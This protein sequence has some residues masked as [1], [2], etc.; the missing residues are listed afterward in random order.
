MESGQVD[1]DDQGSRSGDSQG[2]LAI[3]PEAITKPNTHIPACE[4]NMISAEDKR[5]IV[6]CIHCACVLDKTSLSYATPTNTTREILGR[7]TALVYSFQ[8]FSLL[9]K[10]IFFYDVYPSVRICF[11]YIFTIFAK[12]FLL[13]ILLTKVDMD[14]IW[15][16]LR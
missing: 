2:Q 3:A 15:L 8:Y 9:A 7:S 6:F 14:W 11:V 10:M 4:R 1:T 16:I 13:M 12:K 5:N